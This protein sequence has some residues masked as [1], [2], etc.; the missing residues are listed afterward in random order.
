MAHF[1]VLSESRNILETSFNF[2]ADTQTINE[3]VEVTTQ[4]SWLLFCDRAHYSFK[5][6]EHKMFI[7]LCEIYRAD[8][9][10]RHG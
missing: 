5:K 1:K 9:F 8:S 2:P 10:C 7:C 3:K 4:D 6:N